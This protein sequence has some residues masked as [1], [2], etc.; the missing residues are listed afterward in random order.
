M[1]IAIIFIVAIAVAAVVGFVIYSQSQSRKRTGSL[2]DRFGP[3]YDRTI[4]QNGTSRRNAERELEARQ[5]RVERLHIKPLGE[6]QR[7]DYTER[8][9]VIQVHFGDDPTTSVR[10]ADQ[11]VGNVMT[12]RG[13][14]M[15]TWDQR[16][17]DVSVDHPLVVSNYRTAH[18]ISTRM[19]AG[20]ATTEDLRQAMVHYRA[21]FDDLLA[22]EP[23]GARS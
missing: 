13:Y 7:Q 9:R 12:A 20:R 14:P 15:S 6:T 8:W 17:A 11:L 10:E 3:E 4:M 16:A 22:P 5:K 18:D 2:R 23:V 1:T 21:L 19:N